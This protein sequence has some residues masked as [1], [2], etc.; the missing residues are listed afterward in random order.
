MTLNKTRVNMKAL[1]L[2][3]LQNDF[4]PGGALAVTEGD[5]TVEVANAL[6]P[7]F[8]IV[9]ATQ[10]Y[11][12]KEH[13][14]FAS[15][16]P[17]KQVGELVELSGLDQVLWPDHCVEGTEGVEFQSDLDMTKVTKVFP[18]GR[19]VSVDSYSGFYDNGHKNSTGMSEWLKEQGV[20]TVYVMGL[21]TDYC[22]MFTALDAKTEGFETYLIEDGSRGVNLQ[23]GDVENAI[24]EMKEKGI[25]II[26]STEI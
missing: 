23:D 11:H 24:K 15:Q 6:M 10:D 7:T 21:A 4:M 26:Q 20:D 22:V 17:E 5:K 16:Y 18:K 8:D 9:V 3:D 1:I 25:K 12:P 13:G 2:V 19:D 14:S